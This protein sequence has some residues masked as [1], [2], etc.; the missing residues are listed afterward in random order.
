MSNKIPQ[1]QKFWQLMECVIPNLIGLYINSYFGCALSLIWLLWHWTGDKTDRTSTRRQKAIA[2]GNKA[3]AFFVLNGLGSVPGAPGSVNPGGGTVN[4]M[5][6]IAVVPPKT[7]PDFLD[8]V[9]F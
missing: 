7:K 3:I 2:T 6:L 8:T 4:R 5:P 9:E 1:N